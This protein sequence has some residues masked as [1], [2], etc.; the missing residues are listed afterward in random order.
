MK[1]LGL[2]VLVMCLL[3]LGCSKENDEVDASKNENY[4]VHGHIIKGPFRAGSS[5]KLVELDKSLKPTGR[6]FDANTNNEGFYELKDLVL[7]S[8]Y[9]QISAEGF[10][11]N[12]KTNKRSEH[13]LKLSGLFD[14]KKND[15]ANINLLTHLKE[16]RLLHLLTNEGANFN[17]A[18]K[19]A[20]KELLSS[21]GIQ[22]EV[23][24]SNTLNLSDG[25][26]SS[27][28]LFAISAI[29]LNNEESKL[30]EILHL[31]S[32]ELE[33]KGQLSED[34]L[35]FIRRSSMIYN[36]LDYKNNLINHYQSLG[37]SVDIGPFHLYIDLDG[38][39]IVG[40]SEPREPDLVEEHYFAKEEHC[41]KATEQ[42]LFGTLQFM[43]AAHTFEALYCKSIPEPSDHRLAEIYQHTLNADNFMLPSIWAYS[44]KSI[45][46]L[47]TIIKYAN[48]S[49]KEEFKKYIHAAKTYRA[50]IYINMINLWGDL[51]FINEDNYDDFSNSRARTPLNEILPVL[52]S[53]LKTAVEYLPTN[54]TSPVVCSKHLGNFLLAKI[55]VY[56]KNYS[57]ALSQLSAM[58]QLGSFALE[59]TT[60]IFNENSKE[61]IFALT[62][63][64][65]HKESSQ[66]LFDTY[67]KKGD[68]EPLAR[69]TE[70]VLLEA[71]A[72]LRLGRY[73]IVQASINQLRERRGEPL[74]ENPSD[75]ELEAAILAEYKA[76]MPKEQ[77]YFAA[78]K[79]FA[80]AE[81][82]LSIPEYR[83]LL[84]IPYNELNTN[85]V[86]TQNPGY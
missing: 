50:Y 8:P 42:A 65:Y 19:Q 66:Y 49:D 68:V 35:S 43:G 29:L 16:R 38:N 13:S 36:S 82:V 64:D 51:P 15:L 81:E 85:P 75:K 55:E 47:N 27:D 52:I 11:F 40:D 25:N 76:S 39:G 69:Y 78:L 58:S 46:R 6:I 59:S 5:V 28:I 62:L 22:E 20:Q 2:C 33:A 44:Y 63:G 67:V 84:P 12:E 23:N 1:Y 41:I 3:F 48:Q 77:V 31:L 60:K 74:L 32:T 56:Q 71:E 21:F 70:V 54:Q 4:S 37:K 9:V 10:F 73:N 30:P 61:L 34:A 72:N 45:Y 53:D 79:R 86:M 17:D 57:N 24:L 26:K 14:L 18:S 80:K 83:L 7:A